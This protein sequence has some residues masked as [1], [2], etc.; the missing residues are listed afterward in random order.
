MTTGRILERF[1]SVLGGRVSRQTWRKGA[2]AWPVGRLGGVLALTALGATHAAQA[3]TITYSV[4]MNSVVVIPPTM[5]VD[6]SPEDSNLAPFDLAFTFL[7]MDGTMTITGTILGQTTPTMNYGRQLLVTGVTASTSCGLPVP[8]VQNAIVR[9]CYDFALLPV[10][11]PNLFTLGISGTVSD[12]CVSAPGDVIDG[13]LVNYSAWPNLCDGGVPPY[14]I[15]RIFGGTAGP[16]PFVEGGTYGT[17]DP[18]GSIGSVTRVQLG[19]DGDTVVLPNSALASVVQG[20]A[21]PLPPWSIAL[22]LVGVLALG[23]V[24]L[25]RRRG[26]LLPT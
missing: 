26:G 14:Q 4:E 16:L 20:S 17:D 8:L 3:A 6:N 11:A 13:I 5:V 15:T 10:P 25:R 7:G 21:V 18:C 2:W 9:A 1:S 24:L 19:P 23:A 22:L 12:A